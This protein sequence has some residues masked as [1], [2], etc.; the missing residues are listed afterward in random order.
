MEAARGVC[1]DG[2]GAF[3]FPAVHWDYVGLAA[4][5][6]NDLCGW[7]KGGKGRWGDGL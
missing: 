6:D 3:R 7:G 2:K 5:Y 4:A 1:V